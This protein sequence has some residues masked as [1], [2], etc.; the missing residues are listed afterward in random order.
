MNANFIFK[1][2]QTEP[3]PKRSGL[4][5]NQFK[6]RVAAF[7]CISLWTFFRIYIIFTAT[8]AVLSGGR[9]NVSSFI[10]I[11][12]IIYFL[13]R[14]YYFSDTLFGINCTKKGW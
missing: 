4:I 11:V 13:V 1:L 9:K 8:G 2:S 6:R 5:L 12:Q 14:A 10:I 3:R 7:V